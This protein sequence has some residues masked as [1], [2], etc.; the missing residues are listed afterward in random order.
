M[1]D[2]TLTQTEIDALLHGEFDMTPKPLGYDEAVANAKGMVDGGS[3]KFT[4]TPIGKICVAL[5]YAHEQRKTEGTVEVCLVCENPFTNGVCKYSADT[6]EYK[7]NYPDNC[8]IRR[9][10]EG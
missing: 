1:T 6:V 9:G 8:P 7:R 5:L 3:L 10:G 4:D 2:R